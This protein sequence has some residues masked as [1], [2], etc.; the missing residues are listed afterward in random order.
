MAFHSYDC[1]RNDSNAM[2][3]EDAA[4]CSRVVVNIIQP[5]T[6][7]AYTVSGHN[8]MY[9]YYVY[10]RMCICTYVCAYMCV[11]THEFYFIYVCKYCSQSIYEVYI[12]YILCGLID[13]GTNFRFQSTRK[14]ISCANSKPRF[15]LGE[16]FLA[17][18]HFDASRDAI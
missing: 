5:H 13:T 11:S 3:T 2:Q 6:V 14:S 9:T 1:T 8:G 17:L 15:E 12:M 4:E 10:V 16:S 18:L 7:Y